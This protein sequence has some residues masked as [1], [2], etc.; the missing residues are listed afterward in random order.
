MCWCR[1]SYKGHTYWGRRWVP[2]AIEGQHAL[3]A[4]SPMHLL[5]PATHV[6]HVLHA[7]SA[8]NN[9]C[10]H[11]NEPLRDPS[12]QRQQ[13]P[14]LEI[15]VLHLLHSHRVSL[16]SCMN[17]IEDVIAKSVQPANSKCNQSTSAIVQLQLSVLAL[18]VKSK[19]H[20][21]IIRVHQLHPPTQSTIYTGT[22]PSI[23]RSSNCLLMHSSCSIVDSLCRRSRRRTS[24]RL[25]VPDSEGGSDS[26]ALNSFSRDSTLVTWVPKML[27]CLMSIRRNACSN[28]SSRVSQAWAGVICPTSL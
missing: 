24:R 2:V 13:R 23:S 9:F 18:K 26:R 14:L 17:L 8:F 11:Q 5:P 7:C 22:L 6:V 27:P 21:Q 28:L 15:G 4:I 10:C 1:Y 20:L 12:R 3:L 16:V 25:D 19:H